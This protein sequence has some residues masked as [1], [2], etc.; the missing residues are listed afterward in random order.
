[1]ATSGRGASSFEARVAERAGEHDLSEAM[2]YFARELVEMERGLSQQEARALLLVVLA[3]LV[4]KRRGSTRIPLG[5]EKDSRLGVLFAQLSPGAD[6][7]AL[8]LLGGAE[9]LFEEG[10]DSNVIGGPGDYRPLIV[11]DGH[12]YHQRMLHS[13]ER[14]VEV[15][16]AR[17]ALPDV[18]LALEEV[19]AALGDVLAKMPPVG[20][21][22]A[23]E[24]NAEQQFALV[25]AAYRPLS[26]ISGGP[27]TGKTSIVV[28]LIRLL[29]RLGVAP[30]EV[31]LAAPTG[32]AAHRLGESVEEQLGG[33][34]EPDEIDRALIESLGAPRTLH[35]LLGYSPSRRD[36]H[37]HENN[38]LR[39]R[40]VV[41]DEASMIDLFLMERLVEAVDPEARLVLLG[42]AEQLPS[43]DAGAVFRD[44][45][46]ERID[47]DRPW[48]TLVEPNLE[49]STSDEVTAGHAVR[50]HKSYRM[51]PTSPAG[52][53]ILKAAR[54]LNEGDCAP[55]FARDD[56]SGA[57]LVEVRQSADEIAC[58]GV[59]M[60]APDGPEDGPTAR[61]LDAFVA[62][63]YETRFAD[64]DDF[65][66]RIT[67]PFDFESGRFSSASSE[68]LGE[69]FDHYQRSRV[70]TIT[71][72]FRTGSERLNAAFHRRHADLLGRTVSDEIESGEP[73]IM[74]QNDYERGLF[75]GDQG[76]VVDV[77]R[78]D[79][80]E[81]SRMVVF[82]RAGRLIPFDVRPLRRHLERAYALTVHKAQGSEYDAVALVLPAEEIPLLTRE[83]LYT[84]M[85]RSR[86]SV[87]VV[88][89][90]ARLKAAARRR[91]ERSS[92]VAARL[93]ERRA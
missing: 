37:H 21:D 47:T 62:W 84:G 67:R 33:L 11:D 91:V 23:M 71:R 1:M 12:L 80:D 25:S 17:L 46:P 45:V 70:L 6:D 26:I 39:H 18:D 53:D 5:F 82:E 35:R 38:R 58:E 42:D 87:V 50:L 56:E 32:K 28:S 52:A 43:V 65:R 92:G 75:N 64:L 79:A 60:F 78:D 83:I 93:G 31:A 19:E 55:L 59:E 90:E 34:A 61:T 81:P 49:E 89:P 29:A 73:V 10:R 16:G 9:G 7:E 57:R 66:R 69:L 30:E 88:G 8:E 15:L 2:V 74:L 3:S 41:V 54:H 20:D 27:G 22:E 77:R 24:L 63:W 76:L 68:A 72:V 86:H 13:E 51:D 40:V 48:R 4:E 36:F 85:T 14:L 44:L